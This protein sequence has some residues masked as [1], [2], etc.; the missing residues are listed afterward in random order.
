[1]GEKIK[2]VEKPKIP[3]QVKEQYQ[4]RKEGQ[5]SFDKILEQNKLLQKSPQ[6]TQ[7]TP[8]KA[9]E[10]QETRVARQQEHGERGKE[11]DSDEKE[12]ERVKEKAKEDRETSG[13]KEQRVMGKGKGK[14]GSDKG[15][16]GQDQGKG[17]GYGGL[18]QKKGI[19]LVKK[20]A[21][22]KAALA[23]QEGTKFAAQLKAKMKT[24]HL[25]QEF[26]QRLVSQ[27]VKFVKVG[28]NKEGDTEVRLDLHERIFRGLQLR[29]SQKGG[30]VSVHFNTSNSE[31]RE[32][33]AG[34]S[35]D[36]KKE[37]EAK[38]VNIGE[39]KVT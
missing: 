14:G 23:A 27:I 22:S 9:T 28:L 11:K 2:E 6:Q 5:S 21:L 34:S 30:K 16:G 37:L 13:V 10:Q 8:E 32:L 35:D 24:A 26:I 20:E 25:S 38:G 7:V 31:V 29:V 1:M 19:K 12:R 4:P 36:I 18:Q 15:S 33:F 39:I 3:E 17:R